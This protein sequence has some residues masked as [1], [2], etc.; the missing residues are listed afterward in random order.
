MDHEFDEY[1]TPV[2]GVGTYDLGTTIGRSPAYTLK[3]GRRL[4]KNQLTPGPG[5]Y[6]PSPAAGRGPSYTLKPK[7]KERGAGNDTPGPATYSLEQNLS[8]TAPSF[9]FKG[10]AKKDAKSSSIGPGAYDNHLYGALDQSSRGFSM[11]ARTDVRHGDL[12]SPGPG[13]YRPHSSSDR[14][15]P[16]YSMGGV[17]RGKAPAKSLI[18]PGSYKISSE[19]GRSTV[20]SI[21]SIPHHEKYSDTPGVGTYGTSDSP[22]K[23]KG[24]AYSFGGVK[25]TKSTWSTPGPN[26]YEIER[27]RTSGKTGFS[28]K[29]RVSSKKGGEGVPGPAMYSLDSSLTQTKRKPPAYRMGGVERGLYRTNT[30]PG[31]GTY[32]TQ[33]YGSIS[34]ET[35]RG[36]TFKPK[37]GSKMKS[38]TPGVGTYSP[39]GNRLSKTAPSYTFGGISSRKSKGGNPGPGTYDIGKPIGRGQGQITIKSKTKR[40]LRW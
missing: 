29:G 24:P 39:T 23:G 20:V 34:K 9:S 3:G 33:S 19:I 22:G 37:I 31:P 35:G 16:C 11:K 2:P 25:K 7:L 36:F 17:E 14:R 10:I 28:I 32:G 21:K 8:A 40:R 5:T 38:E 26:Q 27:P 12:D 18:G 30:N 15:A 13:A 4:G 6:E 1:V